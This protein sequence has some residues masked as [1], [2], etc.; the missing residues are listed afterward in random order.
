MLFNSID[1]LTFFAVV[2]A[3]YLVLTHRAQN[4]WLLAC[5]YWF[6]ACW[7]GRF[8]GLILLSTAVDYACGLRIADSASGGGRRGWLTLSC[9][10]NLGILAVFKYLGFFAE[11]L[12]AV[13]TAAGVELGRPTLHIVLPVGISFY[14]FQTLS[15][16]IDVYR[17]SCKPVR[18]PLEFALFVAFFPQLVAGPI[19]RANVLLPQLLRPRR[20][21]A[22]LV[23]QGGW[24]MLQGY[25]KKV[26]VAD[27]MAPFTEPL[28]YSPETATGPQI[29]A[30]VVCA[31]VQIYGDFSGYTDIA[32]G[33]AKLLG[34]ELMPN[35]AR[36]YLATNPSDFWRRWHIS[37]STWLRDYL[38]IPLGGSRFGEWLTYRNLALTMLLGGLWHGA[39]WNFVAWGAYHGLLLC[40]HRPLRFLSARPRRRFAAAR[41]LAGAALFFPLTC[42][43]WL[44]F[45]LHDLRDLPVLCRQVRDHFVTRPIDEIAVLTVVLLYG[46]MFVL[47]WFQERADD[48]CVVLGWPLPV[49]LAI[50]ALTYS[51]IL[52]CGSTGAGDFIYFQF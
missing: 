23:R 11:S 49:R 38:Y 32:R 36:P 12:Q 1:F 25:F 47:E 39:A 44:L 3:V 29:L 5:S 2:Y 17:G 37:L 52:V 41:Q 48:E 24:L 14:T 22:L 27:N 13:A 45:F 35:F 8:L 33:V 19:E 20:I 16:T 46:P 21:T 42:F 10:T 4:V 9:V 34:V 40:L 7:D 30:G 31:A 18:R 26:V 43:G 51:A 15:Y 28:F 6:Y 50:Y